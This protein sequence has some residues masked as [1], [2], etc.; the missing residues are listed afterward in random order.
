[1]QFK[2]PLNKTGAIEVYFQSLDLNIDKNQTV[3]FLHISKVKG[4]FRFSET[5]LGKEI[6]NL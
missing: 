1:M 2:P 5:V 4:F 6:E 3:F